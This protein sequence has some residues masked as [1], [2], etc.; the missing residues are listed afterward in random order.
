MTITDQFVVSTDH[1]LAKLQTINRHRNV[2]YRSINISSILQSTIRRRGYYTSLRDAAS[3]CSNCACVY[4][5]QETDSV[6]CANRA[7]L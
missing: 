5:I 3:G 1:V 6:V 7:W 2:E 4:L